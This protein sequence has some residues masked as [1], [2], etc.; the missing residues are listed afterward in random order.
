MPRFLRRAVPDETVNSFG[1]L[2]E[3]RESNKM[4]GKL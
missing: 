4:S 3:E 1:F 2:G